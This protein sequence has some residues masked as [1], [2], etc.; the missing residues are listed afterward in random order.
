MRIAFSNREMLHAP[1]AWTVGD[2]Q[3]VANRPGYCVIFVDDHHQMS[4]QPGGV[5]ETRDLSRG[6]GNGPWEQC[7]PNGNILAFEVDGAA[8]G[9]IYMVL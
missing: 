8:Y 9:L 5:V 2:L 7:R 1:N 6:E 4:M 3:P